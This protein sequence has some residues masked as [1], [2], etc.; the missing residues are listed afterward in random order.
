MLSEIARY[1]G[2]D[3]LVQGTIAPDWIET[4]GGIKTQHNVL[5]QIGI[6]TASKYGFKLLEPLRE[7]YKDQVRELARTL[8]VPN[9]IVNRQP[10]PGPGLSI[11]AVGEL[12]LEKLDVVREATRIVEEGLEGMGLSQWFAAAWEYEFTSDEGLSRAINGLGDLQTY[13]FRVRATGVK[14]DSRSYG[15]VVLV[16]GHLVRWDLAYE[17]HRYLAAAYDITHVIYEL[18]NRAPVS[19]SCPLGLWS[20][21]T[22]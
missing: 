1:Y 9:E 8:N 15:N 3:W 13:L 22:S 17:L 19:T 6:D 10:F 14:G 16:K 2:C 11:R 12:T 5:E 18:V 21:M 7:L 4:R 20:L